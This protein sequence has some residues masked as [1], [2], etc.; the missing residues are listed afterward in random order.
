MKSL[1]VRDKKNG[2]HINKAGTK[3]WFLND[4]LHK[5]DGP[6]FIGADGREVWYLNGKPHREDGPAVLEADCVEGWCLND[7]YLGYG[8]A[9]FWKHWELLTD[10]QRN[11]LNL[12]FWLA[13]YST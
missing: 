9:G 12:H 2:L 3:R 13:K 10:V 1:N 11:N 4:K 8:V 6:A 5:L 7:V